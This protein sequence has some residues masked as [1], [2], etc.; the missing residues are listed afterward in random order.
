MKPVLNTL[1]F[2]LLGI[3]SMAQTTNKSRTFDFFKSNLKKEM[4]H[5]T[6]VKTFGEPESDL[7]SGIYIY[8]YTLCDSSTMII[9]C[10]RNIAY[11]KHYSKSGELLDTLIGK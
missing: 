1:I 10:T 6:V 7:G 2:I 4:D 5:K 11:A 3:P 9:G 8:K